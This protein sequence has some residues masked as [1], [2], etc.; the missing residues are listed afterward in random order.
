MKLI[1]K[2]T[3]YAIRALCYIARHKK[4]TVSAKDLVRELGI[5][6]PFL[7]KILL[8]LN[9]KT[10]LRSYKG[11]GGGFKLSRSPDRI[12]ITDLIKAFQG[13]IKLAEHIFRRGICPHIKT[14][15]LKKKLDRTEKRIIA[16]LKAI[17]IASLIRDL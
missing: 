3:D 5:T 15:I 2:N 12:L 4:K 6:R 11:K 10:F 16:D 1:T 13:P 14:C 17:T 9:K 8:R 7:R